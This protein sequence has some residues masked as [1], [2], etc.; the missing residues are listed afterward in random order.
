MK[1]EQEEEAMGR[2]K[3]NNKDRSLITDL[4][5][6]VEKRA[7]SGTCVV[8]GASCRLRLASKQDMRW[9]AEERS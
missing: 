6:V 5:V 7:V 2:R 4:V 9:V 8:G 3:K 1:I